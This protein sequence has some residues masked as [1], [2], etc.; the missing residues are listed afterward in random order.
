MGEFVAQD[1]LEDGFGGVA[2]VVELA[3]VD[4]SDAAVGSSAG[5]GNDEV[6]VEVGV[7]EAAGVVIE[8]SD[9]QAVTLVVVEPAVTSA[10]DGRFGFE[11]LDDGGFGSVD[12]VFDVAAGVV[13]AHAPEHRHRL[14]DAEGDVE[15]RDLDGELGE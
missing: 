13:V 1:R 15:G 9:D 12:G 8:A 5:V 14:G 6:S 3:G 2:D 10:H 11:E 7:A 4:A